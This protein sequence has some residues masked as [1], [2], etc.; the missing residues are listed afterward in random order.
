LSDFCNREIVTW[1]GVGVRGSDYLKKVTQAGCTVPPLGSDYF[2]KRTSMKV[3]FS[4]E[5]PNL[6]RAY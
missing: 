5:T 3:F 1:G 4:F 6:I 2:A